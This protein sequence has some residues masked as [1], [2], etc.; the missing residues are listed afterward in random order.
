M[1]TAK[2]P[3]LPLATSL[4]ARCL[5]LHHQSSQPQG[6]SHTLSRGKWINILILDDGCCWQQDAVNSSNSPACPSSDLLFSFH[7][8][9]LLPRLFVLCWNLRDILKPITLF[10]F[11]ARVVVLSCVC[12]HRSLAGQR[13]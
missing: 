4:P 10:F 2:S 13:G 9:Y 6:S 3:S 12:F 8:A 7:Q 1:F 5:L 11:C